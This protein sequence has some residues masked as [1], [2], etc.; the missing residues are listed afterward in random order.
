MLND[1]GFDEALD[2]VRKNISSMA[3]ETVS[4]KK[5][6]GRVAACD[7]YAKVDS[8]SLD[9]SL[10]DGYA[11]FS[12]DLDNASSNSPVRLRVK[13]SLAAGD[14]P[15]FAVGPG[16]A[17]RIL[18]GAP[19]PE[20]ADAVVAEEFTD[21]GS[22]DLSV[23]APA[24]KGRNI[25]EKGADVHKGEKIADAGC[26]L[27][28]QI[29][30]LMVA[31]GIF[32]LPV[33]CRPKI[34]LLATGSE[35]L[36]PGK[37]FESGRLY[38]SNVALQQAW[39]CDGGFDVQM[40]VSGDTEKQMADEI[41]ELISKV[42]VLITSGGAWKGDRD[43][44]VRVL[45][46][47]GCEMIFHRVRMGPGKAAGMGILDG[48]PVF[49]LPGGPASNEIA[50]LFLA[51]PAVRK[52]A[53]MDFSPY[54]SFYGKLE[55]TVGGQKDWTQ[56]VQCDIEIK[57]DKILLHPKKLKSRMAAMAKTPAVVIIAEGEE[58]IG[59]GSQ[60]EF[61]CFDPSLFMHPC[62]AKRKNI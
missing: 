25:L 18:S 53:G 57:G 52:M 62:L 30:G 35:I 46:S 49:C 28:P 5:A 32:K 20:G 34:G 13:G 43:L 51:Y 48:K 2:F 15:G 17:V 8:P 39:L 42:D 45:E 1:I 33:Y 21:R 58:E 47:L 59:K 3:R 31:A 38:A 37:P 9:A 41:R 7:V 29:I 10:K 50:F 14:A 60:V 11:V 23:F 44:V 54:L 26:V 56:F 6:V 27:F 22:P 12:A 24:Q 40:R 4:V 55:K 36:L 61:V 19:I 16:L